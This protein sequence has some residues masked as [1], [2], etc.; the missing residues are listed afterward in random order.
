[1]SAGL[2]CIVFLALWLAFLVGMGWLARRDLS[3]N[4]KQKREGGRK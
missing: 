4:Y 1:M 3:G 2:A